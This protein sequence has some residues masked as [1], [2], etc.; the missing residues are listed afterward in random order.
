MF[1]PH[2]FLDVAKNIESSASTEAE[3]R[4]CIGRAYYAAFLVVREYG[5]VN[6]IAR[7]VQKPDG[8]PL[9]SHEQIIDSVQRFSSSSARFFMGQ[10]DT[11]KH[12]RRKADYELTVRQTAQTARNALLDAD[13]II[14]WVDGLP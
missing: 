13:A 10:L 14:Q 3:Y 8:R 5:D 4:N 11:L 1:D 12:L 6:S 2:D 9:G 7:S